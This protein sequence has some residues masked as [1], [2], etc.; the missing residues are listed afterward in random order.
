MGC[1][2]HTMNSCRV[3]RRALL[4][5]HPAAGRQAHAGLRVALL[6]RARALLGAARRL[7]GARRSESKPASRTLNLA[8]QRARCSLRRP[9]SSTVRSHRLAICTRG[10]EG[11]SARARQG[12]HSN[13][14]S[15]PSKRPAAEAPQYDESRPRPGS[16]AQ[17]ISA[18]A[19]G[20]RRSARTDCQRRLRWPLLPLAR[21]TR[22]PWLRLTGARTASGNYAGHLVVYDKCY[23]G[24]FA[25]DS[26]GVWLG[27]S[28]PR[29]TLAH[30]TDA[31][32]TAQEHMR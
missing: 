17:A 31:G 21:G 15:L 11:S 10:Y 8:V 16:R 25:D 27:E 22:C 32:G 6:G 24:R 30:G 14:F 26:A 3:T 5:A 9:F 23:A 2:V 12:E 20:A 7:P 18:P 4:S 13:G 1:F 19:S 29:R 28:R